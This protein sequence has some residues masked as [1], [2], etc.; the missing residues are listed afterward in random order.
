MMIHQIDKTVVTSKPIEVKPLDIS[1]VRV[2]YEPELSDI[3]HMV[4]I[5]IPNQFSTIIG[6]RHSNFILV[7]YDENTKLSMQ[8]LSEEFERKA[9]YYY[10]PGKHPKKSILDLDEDN[11]FFI[12]SSKYFAVGDKIQFEIIDQTETTERY[13]AIEKL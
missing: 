9:L 6:S 11:Q 3:K 5:N 10:N 1:K 13:I 7:Q 4:R 12:C 8:P 2:E